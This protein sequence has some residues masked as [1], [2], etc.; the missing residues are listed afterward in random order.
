RG[1][2]NQNEIMENYWKRRIYIYK[3][4]F[5]LSRTRKIRKRLD[6]L[7]AHLSRSVA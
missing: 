3:I 7:K 6:L 4:K 5:F 1:C 2:Y